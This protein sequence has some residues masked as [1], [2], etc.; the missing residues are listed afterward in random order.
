MLGGAVAPAEGGSRGAASSDVM[1]LGPQ[2]FDLSTPPVPAPFPADGE[3][4]LAGRGEG[5]QDIVLP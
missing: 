1:N 3:G 5:D 4:V 2:M